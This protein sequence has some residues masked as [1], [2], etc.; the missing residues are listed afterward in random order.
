MKLYFLIRN[1]KVKDVSNRKY[2]LR[3]KKDDTIICRNI[4]FPVYF[5]PF[6]DRQC[7]TTRSYM[8]HVVACRKRDKSINLPF[9]F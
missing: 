2:R 3:Q 5:C 1:E 4:P 8:C 9:S 6:C 7:A